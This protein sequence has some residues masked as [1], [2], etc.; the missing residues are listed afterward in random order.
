MDRVPFLAETH[1]RLKASFA[2][3]TDLLPKHVVVQMLG[4]KSGP[5]AEVEEHGAKEAWVL[6][7]GEEPFGFAETEAVSEVVG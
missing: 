3:L 4:E 7:E 1:T 6:D 5:I 2:I